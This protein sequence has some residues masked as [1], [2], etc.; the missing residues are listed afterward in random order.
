LVAAILRG[1]EITGGGEGEALPRLPDDYEIDGEEVSR[2]APLLVHDADASQHSAIVDVMKR[3]NLVIE[4]PPG[5]GKSQ[6]ITNIIANALSRDATTSVLF[7]SE[8]RAALEVVRRRLDTAKLG[9][10]C[11]EL[12][13]EKSSPSEVIES[14]KE[15][16]ASQPPARPLNVM[17]EPAWK[18]AREELSGYLDELHAPDEDGET[19]FALFWKSI[20]GDMPNADVPRE[21]R[22][23]EFP[24]SLPADP[25]EQRRLLAEVL[26]FGSMATD[27]ADRYGPR[28][29]SPWTQLQL[30]ARPGEHEDVVD[31]LKTLQAAV[32]EAQPAAQ[33]AKTH[34]LHY[35]DEDEL[36]A[37]GQIP[38]H[39]HLEN[40]ERLARLDPEEIER[41]AALLVSLKNFEAGLALDPLDG[42]LGA[43]AL[44]VAVRLARRDAS[45]M[46][47]TPSEVKRRA[48]E[49][50]RLAT[51]IVAR[52]DATRKLRE[53]L[54]VD[55]RAPFG[56]ISAVCA[57]A[58]ETSAVPPHMQ[59]WL[60]WRPVGDEAVFAKA[61]E[62]W[63]SLM[64]AERE[65]IGRLSGYDPAVRPEAAELREASGALAE[66]GIGLKL[67]KRADLKKARNLAARLGMDPQQ[68]P[69]LLDEFA[70]HLEALTR[71]ERDSSIAETIGSLW[72][73]L[74]TDFEAMDYA[75]KMRAFI[76]DEL[77]LYAHGSR[78]AELLFGLDGDGLKALVAEKDIALVHRT[79]VPE[80]D[81]R[82]T[83]Q[84]L[85]ETFEVLDEERAATV[86]MVKNG[87]LDKLPDIPSPLSAIVARARQISERDRFAAAAARL[88]STATLLPMVRQ[89]KDAEAI[90]AV[91]RWIK[92][93]RA[94]ELPKGAVDRLSKADGAAVR[95]AII[96]AAEQA[97]RAL[98]AE[99]AANAVLSRRYGANFLGRAHESLSAT[100]SSALERTAELRDFLSLEEA[101][102]RLEDSGLKSFVAAIEATPLSPS[103]YSDVLAHVLVRR[104]AERLHRSRRKLSDA[105]GVNLNGRRMVFAEQDKRKIAHDRARAYQALS[106]RIAPAG[107]RG[108]P[109][110]NWTEMA[111][112]NAEKVKEKRFMKVRSLL[113]AGRGRDTGP[114]TLLHDVANVGGEVPAPRHGVRYRHHRRS[115][116]NAP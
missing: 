53:R 51:E 37:A 101:R 86:A 75:I 45:L 60:G 96:A 61:Y 74:Q 14:L 82:F 59:G 42:V 95:D 11:L 76:S 83:G 27:F 36:R 23:A 56:I 64:A 55:D 65:W 7:L 24:E 87:D 72:Q 71:F 31:D 79:G 69:T 109:Q 92:S 110:K 85:A 1:A 35:F 62:R 47:L 91:A 97:L 29:K 100:L 88:A 13:S 94:L 84:S 46:A 6:T 40:V 89:A 17:S 18:A 103:R 39:P 111:L 26:F 32:R 4:G 57:A 63:T 93:V 3:E 108:G 67:W 43:E 34:E 22:K 104:R 10:F 28:V 105:S 44:V 2:L 77:A 58:I 48:A 114:E 70:R 66:K 102:R 49:T 30:R 107:S 19:A 54:G 52:I 68:P 113:P 41:A 21:V 78:I 106:S 9:V 16:L 98:E 115:L 80:I 25:S 15:R 5:T 99:R 116:A 8:K 50:T 20:A 33:A 112:I 90:A 38:A 81:Q 73:G 12:H